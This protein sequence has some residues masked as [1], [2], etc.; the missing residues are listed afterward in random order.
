M[1]VSQLSFVWIPHFSPNNPKIQSKVVVSHGIKQS[2]VALHVHHHKRR[3][4]YL[5]DLIR[6]PL[7][8]QGVRIV[9]HTLSPNTYIE[10]IHF[11][12]IIILQSPCNAAPLP[13][14]AS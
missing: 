9:L 3:D 12:I 10:T 8:I 14:V 5:C 7:V 4:G 1:G 11:A 6:R 2:C 13:R